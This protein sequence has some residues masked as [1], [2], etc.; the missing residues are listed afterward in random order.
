MITPSSHHQQ[1]LFFGTH[2]RSSPN[3]LVCLQTEKKGTMVLYCLFVNV[4]SFVMV[5][6]CNL[7][8]FSKYYLGIFSLYFYL[9]V[10]FFLSWG[11]GFGTH[12]NTHRFV[13]IIYTL[14]AGQCKKL[15]FFKETKLTYPWFIKN[16]NEK[17]EKEKGQSFLL[18]IIYR[19]RSQLFVVFFNSYNLA[20]IFIIILSLNQNMMLI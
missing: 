18:F 13:V 11:A 4:K 1:K 15:L 17:R 20:C 2:H 16:N 8:L 5:T 19:K 10:F 3:L 6:N 12:Q 14:K 9:I 7:V